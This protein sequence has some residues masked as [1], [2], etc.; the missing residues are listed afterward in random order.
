M[1]DLIKQ[2]SKPLTK[3]DVELRTGN[4]S[5]K[6]ITLLV[7]KTARTDVNRLNEVCGTKWN[8]KHFYDS[9]GLLCCSIGIYDDDLKQWVFRED[10]GTESFTEK[11]KGNYSDS[12]KR[13]GFRWGIG[14]ELYNAPFIFISWNTQRDDRT[15][16]YKA[17]K[18][19]PSSLIIT[20]YE[21]ENKIPKIELSY[22]GEI[23]YSNFQ[24]VQQKPKDNPPPKDDKPIKLISENQV[25]ELEKLIKESKSDRERFL[26]AFKI[27]R[28]EDMPLSS[29]ALALKGL[30]K[31]L[32][33][34][35]ASK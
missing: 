34:I 28:L 32:E 26:I 13:A 19:Y 4:V 1:S 11:E 25:L 2:L 3:N 30:N 24:K 17:V 5:A 12:F 27:Q 29:Y 9:Q 18:F 35:N 8:N 16:K 21:V 10:V 20:R 14:I 31:K 15:N 33:T 6:G 23:V 22:G 7:Y